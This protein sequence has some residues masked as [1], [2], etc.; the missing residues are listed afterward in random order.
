MNIEQKTD[1][2]RATFRS[3]FGSLMERAFSIKLGNKCETENC[4]NIK[5]KWNAVGCKAAAQCFLTVLCILV[6]H[7][8]VNMAHLCINSGESVIFLDSHQIINERFCI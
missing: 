5:M 7:S 1:E 6:S 3:M 2:R 4:M 8:R